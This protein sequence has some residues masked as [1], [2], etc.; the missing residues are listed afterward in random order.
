VDLGLGQPAPHGLARDAL[1]TGD[2]GHRRSHGGVLLGV[3]AHEP[4]APRA[5]LGIDLLRHAVYPLG[6][7]Q[8]RHQTRDGS[9]PSPHS[10]TAA[11]SRPQPGRSPDTHTLRTGPDK[12]QTPPQTGTTHHR[13][14]TTALSAPPRDRSGQVTG[15]SRTPGRN[16]PS[17]AHR[18][19]CSP[20]RKRSRASCA[21]RL[22]GARSARSY[23]PPEAPAAPAALAAPAADRASL[24]RPPSE[25]NQDCR[26][27]TA[28]RGSSSSA[29]CGASSSAPPGAA[30]PGSCSRSMAVGPTALTVR[31]WST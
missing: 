17:L 8:Q 10:L 5:Q 24:I 11:V 19:W 9:P 29:T 21:C 30:V 7:K 15:E 4:H 22:R 3:L 6:L 16:R 13:G 28:R 31:P 14:G 18:T 20:A 12:Q 27:P 26:A 23:S 2:R 25:Q 1:L